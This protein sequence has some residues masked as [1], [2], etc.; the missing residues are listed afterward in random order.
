[1]TAEAIHYRQCYGCGVEVDG[2]VLCPDCARDRAAVDRA[3]PAEAW[4]LDRG[5]R[6]KWRAWFWL[7]WGVLVLVLAGRFI[8]GG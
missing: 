6:P 5:R 8:F 2:A 1:M 3:P 4:D 7:A